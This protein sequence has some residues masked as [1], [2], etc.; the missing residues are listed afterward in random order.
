MRRMRIIGVTWVTALAAA[1]AP[2][3][4][5]QALEAPGLC[6]ASAVLAAPWSPSLVLVADNEVD[7]R[8]FAFAREGERLVY[9][10]AVQLP[11]EGRPHD[12]EALT[13]VGGQ[14]LV[15][16]SHGPSKRGEPKP[17]RA[18]MALYAPDGAQG[19]LRLVR[20]LDGAAVLDAAR[21]DRARCPGLLFVSPPP[22]LAERVC[23]V[24]AAAAPQI[25]GAVAVAAAE[26]AVP[27]VWLGLRTPLLDGSA[28]LL[29]LAAG[30]DALR[31]DAV[32]LVDLEGRGIRDL[33]STG[34]FVAGIAGPAA[35]GSSGWSLWRVK[36]DALR[37]GARLVPARGEAL[38]DGAEGLL[39]L[40]AGAI[41][42]VDTERPGGGGAACVAPARQRFV[43]WPEDAG[44]AR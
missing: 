39:A 40:P 26:T 16:G 25:E 44:A 14:L 29:R 28:V 1:A 7:D 9:R 27:R 13:A 35:D 30:L 32:A 17:K 20:G 22:A 15:V 6:E 24:L 18:R 23:A 33:A 11:R 42:V 10:Y 8:L 21:R 5:D 3:A 37:D 38:P 31:F 2:A 12:A 19:T 36:R 41:V 34:E 4:T 43:P